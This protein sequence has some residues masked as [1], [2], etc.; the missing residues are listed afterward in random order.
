M[1]DLSIAQ[2]DSVEVGLDDGEVLAEELEVDLVLGAVAFE[3]GEVEVEV[4]AAGVASW[5]LDEGREGAEEEAGGGAPPSAAA[6]VEGEDDG[7]GGG[8][9]GAGF[10][11]VVDGDFRKE[12]GL[13]EERWVCC[14]LCH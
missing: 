2:S 7:G 13:V 9:V 3:G 5:A 14:H 1:N 11:A 10:G 8:V 12:F 4:E 6:A